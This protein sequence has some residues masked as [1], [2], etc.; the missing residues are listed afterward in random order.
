[1]AVALFVGAQAVGLVRLPPLDWAVCRALTPL[2]A[3]NVVGLSLNTLCLHYVQA[4]FYQVARALVLP[5][6]VVLTRVLLGTHFSPAVL[7]ACAVVFVGFI[8]GVAGELAPTLAGVFFGVTSSV[9]TALHAV[10]I[11]RSLA[12]VDGQTVVLAYYNNV[13]TAVLLLPV[14][15]LAGEQRPLMDVIMLRIS[16][17]LL[18]GTL[19]AVRRAPR[20]A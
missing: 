8:V 2:V 9:T 5:F 15:V 12:V 3:I 4:S 16:S 13:L 17:T 11:K 20:R 1:M 14:V 6:T 7:G 18:W 10:V 19:V